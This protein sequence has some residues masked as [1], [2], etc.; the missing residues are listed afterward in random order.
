L[1]LIV[2]VSLLIVRGWLEGHAACKTALATPKESHFGTYTN[3]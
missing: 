2:T 1:L 3:L